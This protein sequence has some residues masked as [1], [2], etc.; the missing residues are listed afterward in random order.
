MMSEPRVLQALLRQH[1]SAYI[2]KVFGEINPGTIF[3][4]SWHIEAIAHVLQQCVDGRITRLVITLP[5]RGLKSLCVS[6]AFPTWLLGHRP[7]TEI[8][9]VSYAQDL[10]AQFSRSS[11]QIMTSPWYRD[12][13]PATRLARSSE[14][15]LQTTRNGGRLATS[16]GGALTGMGGDFIIIDDPQKAQDAQSEANRQR[17]GEWFDTTLFSR[18]NDKARGVIIVVMQRVH[19]NDL[20]GQLLAR[21]GWTHL[22]LPAI[23]EIPADIPLPGGRIHQRHAGDVLHPARES[24]KE[25]EQ[26]RQSIGSYHFSA[27]YLQRPAPLEG[28]LIRWEWLVFDADGLVRESSDRIYQ[29]WDMALK[30]GET[31]N[32]SVCTTW[33]MRG[34]HYY[35]LDLYRARADYP[36]LRRQVLTLAEHWRVDKVLI[37]DTAAGA[38][39]LQELRRSSLGSRLTPVMPSGDKV[40]RVAAVTHLFE[41]GFVH[42]PRSAPWLESLRDELLAFPHGSYDDQADSVSQFLRWRTSGNSVVLKRLKGL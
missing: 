40:A 19:M 5:P 16:I 7:S 35:L 36:T 25:L 26:I 21:D 2:Q 4:H 9:C 39:I 18:L 14:E 6:I 22:N 15:H 34:S 24:R 32:F 30:D 3:M 29:S 33:L 31:N 41:Q 23:A 8:I 20:A 12:T 42:L 27:Q 13:F 10:A 38:P 1:Q 28:N 37:E 11:R 17:V